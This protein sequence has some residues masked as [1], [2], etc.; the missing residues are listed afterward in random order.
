MPRAMSGG[1]GRFQ[2]GYNPRRLPVILTPPLRSQSDARHPG[3][4]ARSVERAGHRAPRPF[5]CPQ[6]VQEHI[7]HGEDVYI[8][9]GRCR[10]D[11]SSRPQDSACRDEVRR[12][13]F[14]QKPTQNRHG[15]QKIVFFKIRQETAGNGRK[16]PE[17]LGYNGFTATRQNSQRQ[18][19]TAFC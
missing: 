3:A 6:E 2:P 14:E 12:G 8:P 18:A 1:L 19:I 9:A 10:L 16:S 11:T 13:G 17:V 5:F 4:Y 15:H 7:V